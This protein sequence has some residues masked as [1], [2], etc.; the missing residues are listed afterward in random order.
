MLRFL[1]PIN[2]K[3][4]T[5]PYKPIRHLHYFFFTSSYWLTIYLHLYRQ[6][7]CKGSVMKTS[8]KILH[9]IKREG[10]ITA[11]QLAEDLSITPMGARQHLQALEDEGLLCFSD[12]KVKIGRPARH[13]SLTK[14]GHNGFIDRHNDFTI[15]IIDAVTHLFGQQGLEQVTAERE[16]KIL[17]HYQDQLSTCETLEQRLRALTQLRES[18]GYMAELETTLDGYLLIENHCPICHA[19]KHCPSLCHSEFSI[20]TQLLGDECHIQRTEHIIK[21]ARRCSYKITPINTITAISLT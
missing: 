12:I 16:R 13:W 6:P 8:D 19:A 18:E 4:Q 9:K 3:R 7:K 20:F 15:D 21:G 14:Q 2:Q 5:V 17:H 1:L 10:S 11:R